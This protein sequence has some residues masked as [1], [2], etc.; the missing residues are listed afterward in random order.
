MNLQI[1]FAYYKT[2]VAFI[3]LHSGSHS[4]KQF[5]HIGLFLPA[6]I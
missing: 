2:Y 4:I 5:Y 3:C 6:S 1:R